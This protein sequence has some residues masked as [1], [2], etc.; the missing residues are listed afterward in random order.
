[1]Q[2]E[3]TATSTM[4]FEHRKH[5]NRTAQASDV[6]TRSALLV[7]CS[8]TVAP[9]RDM[10]PLYFPIGTSALHHMSKSENRNTCRASK[11]E[12]KPAGC[13]KPLSS[14]VYH[15][16]KNDEHTQPSSVSYMTKTRTN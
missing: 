3:T 8:C 15:G 6:P 7:W 10:W 16:R 1:M 2:V 5:T 4:L 14:P 9:Q 13:D 12:N 11:D